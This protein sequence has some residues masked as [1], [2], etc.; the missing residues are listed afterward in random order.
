LTTAI[1]TPSGAG[2]LATGSE[3]TLGARQDGLREAWEKYRSYRATVA[4]L[5]S[6][7]DRQLA[8]MG[9]ARASIRAHVRAAIYGN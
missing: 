8:D 2:V 6:L 4:E 9:I 5:K 1:A 3:R 7:T